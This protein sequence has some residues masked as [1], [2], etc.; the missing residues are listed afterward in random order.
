MDTSQLINLDHL[1]IHVHKVST[2]SDDTDGSG[3]TG[4]GEGDG[5][6]EAVVEIP[7]EVFPA[8]DAPI[9]TVPQAIYSTD[10]FTDDLTRNKVEDSLTFYAIE[11]TPLS[12]PGFS[13]SD[14][15]ISQDGFVR[16]NLSSIHGA[17]TFE[18]SNVYELSTDSTLATSMVPLGLLVEHEVV[19]DGGFIHLEV[20]G[21]I[22]YINLALEELTFNPSPNYY[23][24]DARMTVAVDDMGNAG[25]GTP[26]S[27]SHTIRIY[28]DPVN[29]APT[30]KT[31]AASGE[32][33]IFILDEQEFMRLS[34][35]SYALEGAGG[36]TSRGD[37]HY[38][39][40][41]TD[42]GFELWRLNE[43]IV[44]SS[45]SRGS[46]ATT[47]GYE[48]SNHIVL[49][50][51][52]AGSLDWASRQFADIHN[53]P[54]GSNPRYFAEYNGILY[55]QAD[56]GMHG[57]EL[58]R[59]MG[60]KHNWQQEDPSTQ[61]FA[62]TDTGASNIN[63]EMF[64][65][66]LPGPG[67]GEPASMKV[68]S[69]YL[70]FSAAGIDT[71][72]MVLPQYRDSCGSLRQSSFDPEVYF[73]VSD[74]TTWE[75]N[76]VYDCPQGYHWASTEEGHRHFTSYQTTNEL[77]QWHSI[78]ARDGNG[79][80]RFGINECTQVSD[81]EYEKAT[82]IHD[83]YEDKAY[84]DRCGWDGYDYGGKTRTH[85]R[86]RDSYKTGEYKH[87]GSPDSYRPG[88]DELWAHG[89][90]DHT[91]SEFAG[92]VCIRSKD[93]LCRGHECHEMRSGHEL[94]RTD[95]TVEWTTRIDDINPGYLSSR[96]SDLVS[97]GPCLYFAATKLGE[98][99]ELWRTKGNRYAEAEMVSFGRSSTG[100]NPG[101]GNANPEFLTT[102]DNA[103]NSK[104]YLYF[105][106]T[107][108]IRGR[109]LWYVTYTASTTAYTLDYFDIN[110][111]I[112]SSNPAG[113]CSTGGKL[114]IYFSAY[115]PTNGRELW[116]SDESGTTL[117]KDINSG[118]ASSSP[119][120][121]I[122]FNNMIYFKASDGQFGQEL[123]ASDGTSAGTSLIADIKPGAGDSNP[124][125]IAILTSRLNA[126]Q[127]LIMVAQDGDMSAGDREG[128]GGSQLWR[129][130]G[131]TLGTYR[132]FT[133]T[134]NDIY[135]DFKSLD[136][137][138]PARL[139]V[140][141]DAVY[142]PAR[143]STTNRDSPM[144][145]LAHNN[146]DVNFD[147]SY[148]LIVD[149]VDTATNGNLT[150]TL[151]VDSGL[152]V[153]NGDNSVPAS[154]PTSLK[155][156]VAEANDFDRIMIM[157]SLT[158]LGHTVD[159]FTTAEAAFNATK[160]KSSLS[161]I[162]PL[163]QDK[164]EY[165]CIL[166]N[167]H[168]SDTTGT[169]KDG[170]QIVRALRQWG[171]TIDRSRN[172]T[173]VIMM[174]KLRTYAG[175]TLLK[176]VFTAGVDKFMYL[177]DSGYLQDT[178]ALE[179]VELVN[180]TF[181]TK[182]SQYLE[183]QEVKFATFAKEIDKF[184]TYVYRGLNITTELAP[185]DT[186]S[187]EI[188]STLP[189]SLIG[190]KI[191]FQG[192]ANDINNAMKKLFYYASGGTSGNISFSI[193]ISDH[194]LG[195]EQ[196]EGDMQ[197]T[198][199]SNFVQRPSRSILPPTDGYGY[200]GNSSSMEAICDRN[201]TRKTVAYLPLYVIAVNQAPEISVDS[202]NMISQVQLDT[203]VPPITIYDKDIETMSMKN[204]FGGILRPSVTV[205]L[206]TGIGKVSLL[207]KEKVVL[208]Q[209]TGLR[210]HAVVIRGP[211]DVVNKVLRT[212]SYSCTFQDGCVGDQTD[213]IYI[214]V[215][216]EGNKGKGGALTATAEIH[217]MVTKH[218]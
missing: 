35:S 167:M 176:D 177:P 183:A 25:I 92:I 170:I 115:D 171:A 114:P 119:E 23:G 197:P 180:G 139:A 185:A 11:D 74:S 38:V 54:S 44:N 31:P 118:V 100:I 149:D 179:P 67:S 101:I 140:F 1:V 161:T 17:I 156:A 21:P 37:R 218:Q 159:L 75:P 216:D 84:Y 105:A 19:Q 143:F 169:I 145:G 211:Y 151:E 144:G 52:G 209:G 187:T 98:G 96:P 131:T 212:I 133:H 26:K 199:P 202:P 125:Y 60:S 41:S 182:G 103:D 43:P 88:I 9:L 72:W 165:D 184:L 39:K 198:N 48:A 136:A 7:I 124:S 68:H 130:D 30:V 123:W 10:L 164:K 117:V 163:S 73:A 166:V 28:V 152:I 56:D 99:R 80:Q 191:H 113:F 5:Y 71:S 34:G 64:I 50:A 107:D 3:A 128:L 32:A 122:F 24:Y 129:S 148:A 192:T 77:R 116:A 110:P 205:T 160:E 33:P 59:D 157:N 174:A 127:Y 69:S 196:L 79:D 8:N 65:D 53:G 135:M 40:R 97:F 217:V 86:F 94:W 134:G 207:V 66:L 150:M 215:D 29:D 22:Q 201:Q 214:L 203:P 154:S 147:D 81:G 193:T 87:A 112:E 137:Q 188:I 76:R 189:G 111:G 89:V 120:Y 45:H 42:T 18:N 121:L 47:S 142:M 200:F 12:I 175:N 213:T 108:S 204:A 126:Q 16:L 195:C 58:W 46:V 102:A 155:F 194:P 49:D 141:E 4:D 132:C 6:E 210:D 91:T 178:E 186:P 36:V 95:G 14:I 206:T 109:E 172:P 15:D 190:T 57:K 13:V 51:N 85:F 138:H 70:Y 146:E 153:L 181:T 62:T 93:P 55:F 20:I 90:E 82:S 168:Y 83:N 63:V 2:N 106:A 173:K 78:A 104:S 27:D 162:F 61:T 158:N 208:L